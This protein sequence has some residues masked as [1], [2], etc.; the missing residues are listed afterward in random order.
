[1]IFLDGSA[2]V[3]FPERFA[4]SSAQAEAPTGRVARARDCLS[5]AHSRGFM[6]GGNLLKG[7]LRNAA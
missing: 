5:V 6:D 1:M 3:K 2:A 4:R 7:S